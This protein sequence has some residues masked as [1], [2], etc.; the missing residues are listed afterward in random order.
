MPEKYLLILYLL[1]DELQK[2]SCPWNNKK[3]KNFE[4]KRQLLWRNSAKCWQ[5]SDVTKDKFIFSFHGMFN[6]SV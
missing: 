6:I 4:E 5:Q 1:F 3:D 2:S